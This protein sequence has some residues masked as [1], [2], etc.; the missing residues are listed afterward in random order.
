MSDDVLIYA[1][2]ER[3]PAM[4]HEIPIVIGDPFLYVE[5]GGRRVVLTNTLERDR[6]ARAVP[7][8]ELVLTDEVGRD[9]LI[10]SGM[11]AHE[12]ALELCARLCARVGLR[13][14]AVPPELPVELA[15]RLRADGVELRPDHVLF[16]SRRRVK[17]GAE[18]AGGHRAQHAA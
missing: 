10:A 9:E 14:A 17:T 6:L 15:D 18:L 7:D 5:A 3:S 12:I 1:D 4:R 2:T 11:P 8:A 13:T 16:E